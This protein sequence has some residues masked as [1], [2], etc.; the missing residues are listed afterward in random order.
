MDRKKI[1][2]IVGEVLAKFPDM[3]GTIMVSKGNEPIY[4]EGF[5]YVGAPF[6]TDKSAQYLKLLLRS[7]LRLPL[8]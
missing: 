5:S 3:H 8:F 7:S 6:Q 2:F 1:E 4:H